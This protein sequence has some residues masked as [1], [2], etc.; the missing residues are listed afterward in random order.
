MPYPGYKFAISSRR[1]RKELLR[2]SAIEPAI[3]PDIYHPAIAQDGLLTRLRIPGGS[4]T[5]A[6][7]VV[8]AELLA[9]IGLDYAQVTNRANLQLR[10]LDRPIELELLTKLIACGLAAGNTAI[11]GIRSVMMSPLAGIDPDETIDVRPLVAQWLAYL[12]RHPE[13]GILSTKFSVG[14]DG[15]GKVGISDRPN[16]ITLLAVKGKPDVKFSLH[17]S[18]GDRGEP[19]QPVGINL[20]WDECVPMLGAIAQAYRRG[21]E[22]IAPTSRRKPRLR[23]I[24]HDRGLHPCCR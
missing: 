10:A 3:C 21:I 16:D 18:L 5:S 7:C 24:L 4:L 11:D 8:I 12:D 1:T 6:Q 9:A 13:L 17:L 15:G 2:L 19:P 20:S 22:S 23:E 14:F